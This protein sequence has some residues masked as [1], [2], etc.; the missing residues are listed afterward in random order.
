MEAPAAERP[1]VEAPAAERPAVEAPAAERPA[2]EAPAVKSAPRK[3]GRGGLSGRGGALGPPGASAPFHVK[4]RSA[5]SMALRKSMATVVGP[6]PPTRGV[7]APA[8]APHDSATSG[9]R[10]RPS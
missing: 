10:R 6:T 2:M 1:A 5:A 9:R 3:A 8:T 4:R 7:I